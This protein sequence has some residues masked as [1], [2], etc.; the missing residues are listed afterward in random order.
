[1]HAGEVTGHK[2]PDGL[3]GEIVQLEAE[4][5]WRRDGS[6]HAVRLGPRLL[7]VNRVVGAGRRRRPNLQVRQAPPHPG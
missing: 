5:G 6:D 7:L 4:G 3:A 2:V 1:M